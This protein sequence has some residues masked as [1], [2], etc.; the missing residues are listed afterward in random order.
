MIFSLEKRF[1]V[2]LVLP[3]A[4]IVI[5]VGFVGFFYAR[6]FLLQQ[7]AESTGLKLDKAAHQIAMRLEDRLELI[8]L[9]T[10]SENMPDHSV[11]Q[12]FLVQQLLE[13]DGVRFVDIELLDKSKE[14][15]V[16]PY[17]QG[18]QDAEGLYTMELCG[19]FGFC[20]P[21]M[22][23]NAA[24]RTLKIITLMGDVTDEYPKRLIVRLNFD[25]FLSPIKQM[26]LWEG[27]T[28]ALVTGTGQFLAYTDKSLADRRKLG[29]TGDIL[30][31]EVLKEIRHKHFGTVF[32]KGHP[33]DHV[34]GF[35]R[36]PFINWYLLLFSEGKV[37]LGPMVQ[38]RFYYTVVGI[39][40]LIIV[41]CL[42]HMTTR[43]V[44]RSIATI[45]AAA[46]RIQEGDYSVDLPEESSDEIGQL[47]AS[48]NKMIKGL[49]QRDLIEHTF[50]RYVDK[51]IAEELMS[52]PEALRLGGELR[53][54][55]I[56][57]S[58]LRNFTAMSEKLAPQEVIKMLNRYFSRMIAVIE[59]YR[60]IIVDFYGDS[61]LVFFDGLE[62][63]VSARA[64]DALEC[65][66]EMQKALGGFIKENLAR[67]LPPVSMGIG[68]HTGAVIV[69]N[70]GTESRAKYGI[71]GSDVNL[72]D[73]IQATASGGKVVISERTY[74]LIC[75][76]LK[77]SLQFSACLKGV[78]DQK[79]LYEIESIEQ[80]CEL[81]GTA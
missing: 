4:L 47:S 63:D 50:G 31:K 39:A 57:M 1:L 35:Y 75:A 40:A 53:T 38:F 41:L 60:G 7:W 26:D 66:L 42:I 52:K 33:P 17:D 11:L 6:Y 5:G 68:I 28:A 58:D 73:R 16:T 48:F 77:V 8:K 19:D 55:T 21:I 32:S 49:K 70:I 46:S 3:V 15:G 45:S 43:S 37:V 80:V 79:N 64:L 9:I 22:D 76:K 61:I 69:G 23:P 10:K 18:T 29:E 2:F 72:T 30:E 67:G 74:E 78:E 14:F 51:S 44:G 36:L 54:V 71:V 13:K 20:A 24:D 27:S 12:T 59:G 25:S 62:V 81:Q 65:A 56:M 34:V